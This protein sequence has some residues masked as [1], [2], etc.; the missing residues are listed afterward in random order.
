MTRKGIILAGGT[1]TRLHPLTYAVSKQLMPVYDKPLIYYPLSVLMLAGI[2]EIA[3]ITTP[4]QQESFRRLFGDGSDIGLDLSYIPQPRPEGLAQAYI[5]AEDWLGGAPSA[6]ILG[7]N[8]FY[9]HGLSEALQATNR[10]EDGATIFGYQV[11]DPSQYGVIAFDPQG[12]ATSIEE[13][14]TEPKS[15]FAATGLY[16]LDNSASRRARTVRPSVRGE[17]EIT[18]LLQ[19]YLD[20]EL[21]RVERLGRGYAWFD[22]GTHRSLLDAGEFV[23]MIEERQGLKLGC[24]EEVAFNLGLIDIE[25]L[26]RLASP[27]MKTS[28]GQY[29]R[30]TA[31]AGAPGAGLRELRSIA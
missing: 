17:L 24:I 19:S 7:D 31:L 4:A 1:G 11:A 30:K 12:R 16:F 29:L 28:Y 10:R 9:G 25:Q 22:T 6:M 2:S 13:K 5:L 23:R 3:I 21:L 20:D 27:L 14:P 8:I 26:L 15:D 18:D